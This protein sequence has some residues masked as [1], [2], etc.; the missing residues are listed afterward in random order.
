MSDKENILLAPA[1]FD[2]ISNMTEIKDETR[3]VNGK[4]PEL[5]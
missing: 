5:L 3:L 2:K 4:I 1:E